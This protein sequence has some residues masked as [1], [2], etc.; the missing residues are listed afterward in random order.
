MDSHISSFQISA[1]IRSAFSERNSWLYRSE[2]HCQA[3]CRKLRNFFFLLISIPRRGEYVF[4]TPDIHLSSGLHILISIFDFLRKL[5]PPK[6]LYSRDSVSNFQ[7]R[8]ASICAINLRWR[9]LRG[10]CQILFQLFTSQLFP[11]RVS[12][13]PPQFSRSD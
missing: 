10:S 3:H 9:F 1:L 2:F 13:R 11:S 8:T 12:S 6:Y 4:S 7:N 5:K